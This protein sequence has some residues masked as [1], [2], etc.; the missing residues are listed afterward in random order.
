M[1]DRPRA[2]G[3]RRWPRSAVP[4]EE[5]PP[6]PVG[7][8]LAAVGQEL[9]LPASAALT[10]VVQGWDELVGPALAAHTTVRSLRG[11]V[12]TVAVDGGGW[13]TQLRYLE[14]DV[15]QHL[16]ATAAGDAVQSLRVVVIP[17]R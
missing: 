16:A 15:L 2:R 7:E 9:G 14:A 5:N 6:V 12:L 8:A 17:G 1:S 11:G 3:R 4:D 13:A 10:A